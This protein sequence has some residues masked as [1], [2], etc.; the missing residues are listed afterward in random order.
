MTVKKERLGILQKANEVV[1]SLL[2]LLLINNNPQHNLFITNNNNYLF[3]IYFNNLEYLLFHYPFLY[4]SISKKILHELIHVICFFHST[5]NNFQLLNTR[6]S[7]PFTSES[8]YIYQQIIKE[9]SN[10][11]KRIFTLLFIYSNQLH[12]NHFSLSHLEQSSFSSILKNVIS[13]FSESF[14]AL[15][16]NKVKQRFNL[17]RKKEQENLFSITNKNEIFVEIDRLTYE[18]NTWLYILLD[19]CF[20]GNSHDITILNSVTKYIGINGWLNNIILSFSFDD[21]CFVEMIDK[22]SPNILNLYKDN[23]LRKEFKINYLLNY[24]QFNVDTKKLVIEMYNILNNSLDTQLLENYTEKY[25]GNQELF[26]Y[27]FYELIIQIKQIT[28]SEYNTFIDDKQDK[29]LSY[30]EKKTKRYISI[31]DYKVILNNLVTLL[32]LYNEKI[33]LGNQQLGILSVWDCILSFCNLKEGF[34]LLC[35]NFF[36]QLSSCHI[37]NFM[38]FIIYRDEKSL[39]GVLSNCFLDKNIDSIVIE[40]VINDAKYTRIIPVRIIEEISVNAFISSLLHDKLDVKT[41]FDSIFLL[42]ERCENRKKLLA[43]TCIKLCRQLVNSINDDYVE[44]LVFLPTKETPKSVLLF[45]STL[46]FNNSE[47]RYIE[48]LDTILLICSQEETKIYYSDSFKFYLNVCFYWATIL[49][50]SSQINFHLSDW[51]NHCINNTSLRLSILEVICDRVLNEDLLL[52]NLVIKPILLNLFKVGII[53]EKKIEMIVKRIEEKN[54]EIVQSKSSEQLYI[55]LSNEFKCIAL[56][57]SNRNELM[58]LLLNNDKSMREDIFNL[59]R[60]I[61]KMKIPIPLI[62]M[63]N[64]L[65]L[66]LPP[67]HK[68]FKLFKFREIDVKQIALCG[69]S[70][71]IKK[72]FVVN[73]LESGL[74]IDTSSLSKV[75]LLVSFQLVEQDIN[76]LKPNTIIMLKYIIDIFTKYKSYF[77]VETILLQLKQLILE[78]LHE[79][80][81]KYLYG[82]CKVILS[83]FCNERTDIIFFLENVFDISLCSTFINIPS[84]YNS[85]DNKETNL[86]FDL[87]KFVLQSIFKQMNNNKWKMN[88]EQYPVLLQRLVYLHTYTNL[89]NYLSDSLREWFVNFIN[90]NL[91]KVH[92]VILIRYWLYW[93]CLEYE[94]KKSIYKSNSIQKAIYEDFIING[95]Y[96]QSFLKYFCIELFTIPQDLLKNIPKELVNCI[97]NYS[98]E[99][100]ISIDGIKKDNII[101]D[102]KHKYWFPLAVDYVLKINQGNESIII[103]QLDYILENI[104]YFIEIPTKLTLIDEIHFVLNLLESMIQSTTIS[105]TSISFSKLFIKW[106]YDQYHFSGNLLPSVTVLRLMNK[107]PDFATDVLPQIIERCTKAMKNWLLNELDMV[108]LVIEVKDDDLKKRKNNTSDNGDCFEKLEN[109]FNVQQQTIKKQKR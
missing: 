41:C 38:Q 91:F 80:R 55:T 62:Y 65:K 96:N 31:N 73:L 78:N 20:L 30:L 92:N 70:P 59:S 72:S 21:K 81:M 74:L 100:C 88:N 61:E 10:Q 5:T 90:S 39:N 12:P 16:K 34:K 51:L 107:I 98:T 1:D 49:H 6:G 97:F 63:L 47:K 104:L 15:M 4:R 64:F 67:K 46:M 19:H 102:F 84:N 71:F 75:L 3:E 7:S 94:S 105:F 36:P 23:Y 35:S 14:K 42:S 50:N 76:L 54:N 48:L 18:Y 26:T 40:K 57:H 33:Q 37:F 29:L 2:S 106:A 68:F 9:N 86:L 24:K 79:N 44:G 52:I 58:N 85:D 56:F 87:I 8:E 28:Y 53:E 103:N 69:D 17:E 11:W 101:V 93:I 27:V 95:Q 89:F 82:P 60:K 25:L 13:F 43:F 108:P 66:K 83:S 22:L 32:Q 99:L 77:I 109:L 45:L